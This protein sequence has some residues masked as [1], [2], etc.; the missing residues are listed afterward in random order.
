MQT[1]RTA[2][3]YCLLFVIRLHKSFDTQHKSIEGVMKKPQNRRMILLQLESWS[4]KRSV[5]LDHF[6]IE[7]LLTALVLLQ[8][9]T[10]MPGCM[11]W[12]Y[13]SSISRLSTLKVLIL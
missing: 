5:C 6:R 7:P 1:E 10:F 12:D 8:Y 11:K 2:A 3:E 4:C 9:V 13:V